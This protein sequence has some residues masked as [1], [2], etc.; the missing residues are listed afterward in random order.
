MYG[1]YELIYQPQLPTIQFSVN[2]MHNYST[3]SII[4]PVWFQSNFSGVF[5]K[6]LVSLSGILFSFQQAV[7]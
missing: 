5:R 3:I 1:I 7:S 2:F 4:L 6:S